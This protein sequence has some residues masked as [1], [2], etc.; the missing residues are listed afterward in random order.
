LENL[1]N[2][3]ER[4]TSM[5]NAG[6]LLEM[7]TKSR[8]AKVYLHVAGVGERDA[9]KIVRVTSTR[10]YV[11]E[12]LRVAHLVASGLGNCLVQW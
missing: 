7:F 11:P 6:E 3:E 1:P 12:P 8:K 5:Q 2:S 9:E 4:W 10:S